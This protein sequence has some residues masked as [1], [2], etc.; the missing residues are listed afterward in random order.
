M[1]HGTKVLIACIFLLEVAGCAVEK[2]DQRGSQSAA[3]NASAAD[4]VAPVAGSVKENIGTFELQMT[5][6]SC[7]TTDECSGGICVSETNGSYCANVQ[8][9]TGEA[10]GQAKTELG[11]V[12]CKPYEVCAKWSYFCPGGPYSK[13]PCYRTCRYWEKRCLYYK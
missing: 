10:E 8:A 1:I 3:T 5:A 12:P 13:Q 4:S 6:T 7:K 2:S 9:P 11:V